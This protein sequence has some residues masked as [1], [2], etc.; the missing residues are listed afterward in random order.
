LS[1]GADQAGGDVEQ[2]VAQGGWR[3]SE[4]GFQSRSIC[5]SP[6]DTSMLSDLRRTSSAGPRTGSCRVQLKVATGG[7]WYRGVREIGTD[8]IIEIVQ[9]D[10]T[11]SVAS[12][13][14]MPLRRFA[15]LSG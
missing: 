9:F 6:E 2:A 3:P 7:A 10:L 15:Q 1:A 5:L 11:Y 13:R 8:R 12:I 14:S 4:R